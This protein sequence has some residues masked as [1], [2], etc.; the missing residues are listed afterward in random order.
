VVCCLAWLQSAVNISSI[1]LLTYL[2]DYWDAA[3]IDNKDAFDQQQLI[4]AT[5][6]C[7]NGTGSLVGTPGYVAATYLNNNC[8]GEWHHRSWAGTFLSLLSQ[9]AAVQSW[10]D[11]LSGSADWTQ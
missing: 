9:P 1:P 3:G 6:S 10:P 5:C 8:T 2:P 11:A 4:N 7:T